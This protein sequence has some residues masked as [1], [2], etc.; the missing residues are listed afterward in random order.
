MQLLG[1]S[2]ENIDQNIDGEL[3]PRLETI[4]VVLVH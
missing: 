3:V 2:K 1:S 4:D